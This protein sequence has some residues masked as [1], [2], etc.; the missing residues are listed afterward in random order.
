MFLSEMVF[1]MFLVVVRQLTERTS[2]PL[3]LGLTRSSWQSTL[4]CCIRRR[5]FTGVFEGDW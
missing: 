2:E 5:W 4:P 3:V 1:E